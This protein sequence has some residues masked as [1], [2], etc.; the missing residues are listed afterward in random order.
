MLRCK[1]VNSCDELAV[2]GRRVLAALGLVLGFLTGCSEG[3]V[4][5]LQEEAEDVAHLQPV[6]DFREEGYISRTR[7]KHVELSADGAILFVSL[8]GNLVDPGHE[9]LALDVQRGTVLR[10][11]QVGSS[12]QGL[13]LSPDGNT[14]YVANQ[15][16]PVLTV[17]DVP[18]LATIGAI[19]VSYYAQ[20]L[21][22]S[23]DGNT[24]F[25]TNRWLDAVEEIR[26][27]RRDTGVLGFTIP[28]GTNPRD[29]VIGPG[30]QIFVGSVASTSI[31]MIDPS[32]GIETH[33]LYTNSPVNGL[34]TNGRFVFAATLGRGDGHPKLASGD[35][36]R[37]DGTESLGFGDI[38]NDIIVIDVVEDRMRSLYRYTS[39]TA[40][41]SA[42]DAQ[43]DYLASEMI[44]NGAL[45]E[46]MVVRNDRLYVTMSS[47]DSVQVLHIDSESGALTH[48]KALHT[49]INP[50]ELAVSPDGSTIFTADRLGDTVSQILVDSNERK[51][52]NTATVSIP[53]PGNDYETGEMLFHSARIS[54]EALPSSVHPGGDRAGDKSCNH[55]HIE[56]LT[57]GKVWSVGIGLLVP[58]GG[59]RMPPAA[60]NIRDTEP[61]FWEGTQTHKDFDLEV[62]EFVPADDF[63]CDPEATEEDPASCVERDA[64]LMAQVGMNFE[65]ISVDAIGEFL[66]GRPRLLPNP[67]AQFPTQEMA[68]KIERGRVLFSEQGQCTTCHPIGSGSGDAFTINENLGAVISPSPLDNGY[69]FKDEVDGN[70]NVPS[71]RGLWDR[72]LVYFHDGRAKSLRSTILSSGHNGLQTNVDGCQILAER[73]EAFEDGIVRPVLD[74]R[75][76]NEVD[77]RLDTH[78][79]TSSMTTDMIEDLEAFVLSIE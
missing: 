1:T 23:G 47:S 32:A 13:A 64:F 15:F 50:F 35:N 21:V 5:L 57:D 51:F 39:D 52:W 72:P 31:S 63:G 40:E 28:V 49:G 10:R 29:I 43:G 67:N 17:I 71:L 8:E 65:E 11:I 59:Q 7:P 25:V 26:L 55:C 79:N 2:P 69:Q 48:V 38:N 76:C 70:F 30:G 58:L 68:E 20:D 53:Y 78:G 60:R 41:I 16:S 37:G 18:S 75:G 36:Y 62:N 56:T 44:V 27:T 14:L 42:H 4:Y 33:R 73:V 24:I 54:S 34:S 45:P 19:P 6:D 61:L 9:V 12:P 66:K 77:G 74:G 46:Q 3:P 22:V